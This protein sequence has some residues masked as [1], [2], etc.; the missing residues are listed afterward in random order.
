MTSLSSLP[1]DVLKLILAQLNLMDVLRVCSTSKAL[2]ALLRQLHEIRMT[3]VGYAARTGL[4]PK[5]GLGR[6]LEVPTLRLLEL[7]RIPDWS[8]THSRLLAAALRRH[9][10]PPLTTLSLAQSNL[11]GDLAAALMPAIGENTRS[12]R[13]TYQTAMSTLEGR[14]QSP[15]RSTPTRRSP[16]STSRATAFGSRLVR[17]A[18]AA[19]PLSTRAPRTRRSLI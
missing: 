18:T 1:S 12:R 5:A 14:R 17:L 11:G 6:I 16:L 10:T 4:R 8:L 15:T 13:S 7:K 19:F 3:S 9:G 2:T